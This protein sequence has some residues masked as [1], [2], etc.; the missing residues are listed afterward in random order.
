M[1]TKS[2]LKN[3][4]KAYVFLMVMSAASCSSNS[5]GNAPIEVDSESPSKPTGLVATNVTQR[6]LDLIWEPAT[7]NVKVKNYWLYQDNEFLVGSGKPSYFLDGLEPGRTYT[8]QIQANDAAG[9]A[10][11]LSDPLEV[12][13]MDLLTAELQYDSGNLEVYLGTLMDAVP[14]VSGNN[15]KVPTDNDLDQWGLII[16]ALLENNIEQAVDQA[17]Y[18]NYQVVEFTDTESTPNQVYYILKEFSIRTNYWGTFVFSK[19][20]KKQNLVLAAPH[21]LHDQNTGYQAAYVFRQNVAKA[22]FISGAH[23]C[24]R[25]EPTDCSGTTK[26]CSN[27]YAPY[28]V[29]DV[30]HNIYSTF[31]RTTEIMYDE[32]PGSVFVQLHGFSKE[33][34]D[35]YVI[36]SNGT[37]KTP[38]KDYVS[39]IK[40][41]L[42][43]EDSSLT[44]K[45]PHIDVNWTRY[46][47][48]DNT[49]GRFING[50]PNPCNVEATNV[51]GRF[52]H[53]EQESSKLRSSKTG[54]QKVSNA[55]GKVF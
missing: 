52:V 18:V 49:Q 6:S 45:I 26:A 12:S 19:T 2:Y 38:A 21:I 53:I 32:L 10:S 11:E 30:P 48:F 43:E 15:Y 35:P 9:N 47:A 27:N 41:A 42:L 4:L 31:Q 23:R 37:N 1:K 33:A 17:V 29:S 22:L 16:H 40:N 5:D 50:S 14:G 39:L 24:N 44:F 3:L 25:E 8:Y 46:A 7:D 36:M 55:L 51:T 34:S 28:R 54:W 20:P 13:T